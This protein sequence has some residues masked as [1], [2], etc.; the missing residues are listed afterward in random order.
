MSCISRDRKL[1]DKKVDS[2]QEVWVGGSKIWLGLSSVLKLSRTETSSSLAKNRKCSDI[3]CDLPSYFWLPDS[4]SETTEVQTLVLANKVNS[5]VSSFSVPLFP[6]I[7]PSLYLQWPSLPLHST[8]CSSLPSSLCVSCL[9][10]FSSCNEQLVTASHEPE[11]ELRSSS[12]N[13]TSVH[14]GNDIS[15]LVKIS[16]FI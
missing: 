9:L 8:L 7:S 5:T 16:Y 1:W 4:L 12:H 14:S 3:N 2:K 11:K 10:F 13:S 15:R 6:F